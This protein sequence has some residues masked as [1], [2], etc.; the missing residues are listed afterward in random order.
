MKKSI[1]KNKSESRVKKSL[2]KRWWFWVIIVVILAA[3]FGNADNTEE[4]TSTNLLTTKSTQSSEIM[5]EAEPNPAIVNENEVDASCR[6][7]T[8]RLIENAFEEDYKM[9]AFSIEGQEFNENGDGEVKIL[10]WPNGSS[11]V[12]IKISKQG[13]VYTITYVMVAGL[14]ELDLSVFSDS[15]LSFE[16]ME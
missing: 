14:Y 11:K 10:Y 12:N 16:W 4:S 15:W 5:T 9:T 3:I 1:K 8:K 2:Y 7:L 13:N 6:V